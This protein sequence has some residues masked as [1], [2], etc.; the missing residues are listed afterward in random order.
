MQRYERRARLAAEWAKLPAA[1]RSTCEGC[2]ERL[3]ELILGP[4][5][6]SSET[7]IQD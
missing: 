7:A 2:V 6:Q 4:R 5:R 3:A 1:N